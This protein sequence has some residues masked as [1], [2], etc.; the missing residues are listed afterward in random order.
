MELQDFAETLSRETGIP[1]CGRDVE[2]VA[3]AL[4]RTP[5]FWHII[6]YSEEPV[7]VVAST[8]R[9][10]EEKG[11][12]E[13]RPDGVF[14][15]S[16]GEIAFRNKGIRPVVN[17]ICSRCKGRTVVD[18]DFSEALCLFKSIHGKRPQALRIFDQAFVTPETTFARI[19]LADNH[20]DI[21]GKD[22][23][24]LGD[25]DL[26]GLGLAFTQLPKSVTVIEIDERI[27]DFERKESRHAG[28][29]T[30][31]ARKH[32]LRKPLPEDLLR[33]FDAFFCDPPET[34][35][36]FDAFIGRGAVS[37]KGPGGAGYFGLTSAES[38]FAKWKLLQEG[39]AS[40]GFVLTDL[41]RGFNEYVNWDYA[42]DM[43]AWKMAPVKNR[44]RRNW[45]RSAMLRVE[46]VE[47]RHIQNEDLTDSE[48]YNDLESST[49]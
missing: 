17:H 16:E 12:V 27:I 34:V 20:G 45:Y 39:L 15:T 44:P 35:A 10:F 13:R 28:I 37:L 46:L 8:L 2:R 14:L 38:S 26:V 4:L 36:A 33:C 6:E 11:L 25:D 1:L 22:I 19:A 31:V 29:K 21:R 24:V 3:A 7:P 30:L 48:I 18:D 32:D 47:K 23:L 5:D 41:I 42:E 40:K 9:M 49:V 43:R